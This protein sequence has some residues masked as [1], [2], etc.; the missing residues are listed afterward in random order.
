MPNFDRRITVNVEAEGHRNEHGEYQPGPVT[1]HGLW[2]EK[3]DLRL[4]DV[5]DS[6]GDRQNVE[7]RWTIR[8]NGT[9]Y[10]TPV[11]RLEVV[12]GGDTFNVTQIREAS[13]R[14]ENIRRRYI[15]I[16]GVHTP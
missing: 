3:Y 14:G 10:G 6:G 13:A 15:D 8:Y 5:L 2:A 4:E 1:A 16:V 11:S 9:I 12:D 7:R